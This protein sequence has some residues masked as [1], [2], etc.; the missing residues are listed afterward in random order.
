VRGAGSVYRKEVLILSEHEATIAQ[1]AGVLLFVGR[2]KK[3]DFRCS[4]HVDA[5]ATKSDGQSTRKVLIQA[6]AYRPWHQ[7]Q[8][9]AGPSRKLN[10][11][12]E[13][14]GMLAEAT[15]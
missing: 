2:F 6:E 5:A 9:F 4:R 3:T 13:S 15:M 12:S 7:R 10:K 1:G 11:L 8:S 14:L